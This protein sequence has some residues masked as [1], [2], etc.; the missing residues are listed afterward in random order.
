[1]FGRKD[2]YI[3]KMFFNKVFEEEFKPIH[4]REMLLDTTYG[5]MH[6]LSNAIANK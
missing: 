6:A 3:S 4:S 5:N 1:M 2:I